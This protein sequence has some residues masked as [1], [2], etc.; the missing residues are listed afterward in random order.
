MASRPAM[1]TGTASH[2]R[3]PDR[4]QGGRGGRRRTDP[5]IPWW[6]KGLVFAAICAVLRCWRLFRPVAARR[7]RQSVNSPS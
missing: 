6:Q 7:Q 1:S 2:D 4:R 5:G 3:G